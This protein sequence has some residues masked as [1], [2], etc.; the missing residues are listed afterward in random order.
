MGKCREPGDEVIGYFEN[1]PSFLGLQ[2]AKRVGLDMEFMVKF[3][4]IVS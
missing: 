1:T 4:G 3:G 2:K